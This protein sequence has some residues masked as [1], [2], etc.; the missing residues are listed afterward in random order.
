MGCLTKE[1]FVRG[2]IKLLEY[3]IPAA[4]ATAAT[5]HKNRNMAISRESE[6]SRICCVL[7]NVHIAGA[8]LNFFD[9]T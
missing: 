3:P 6:C 5:R 7:Y 2:V 8:C 4:T 1:L 9:L